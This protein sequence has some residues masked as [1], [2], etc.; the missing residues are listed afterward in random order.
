MGKYK[1]AYYS[2]YL[3]VVLGLQLTDKA[4]PKALKEAESILIPMGEYFQI[5]DDYLDCFGDPKVIGKVGRDIEENKCGWLIVTA[6]PLCSQEQRRVIQLLLL[7]FF[8]LFF[9]NS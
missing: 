9:L 1:T 3:P 7:F 5:Q 6:L 8:C 4:S 2:F